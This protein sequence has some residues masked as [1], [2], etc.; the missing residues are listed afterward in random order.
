MSIVIT[1]TPG[2]GKHTVAGRIAD[3]LRLQVVDINRIAI[4]SGLVGTGDVPGEVDISKL[5]PIL[6]EILAEP[7]LVVGHLAPYVL[8]PGQVKMVM[9][10]RRDPYELLLT[11]EQRGYSTSKSR[12]NSGREV[13]GVIFHDSKSIFGSS[14]IQM[15]VSEGDSSQ[16]V[17]DAIRHGRGD[18]V[19]WLG[20][21][22]RNEDLGKFF[23]Y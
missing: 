5:K 23:S 15:R 21:V 17:L 4:K 20:M 6:E 1:G 2:V 19:D 9:V 11:Y 16:R 10:L 18:N 3:K 13:L 12:E 8:S 22:V 14:V 7:S